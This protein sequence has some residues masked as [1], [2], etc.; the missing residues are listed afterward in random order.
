MY[1]NNESYRYKDQWDGAK[2]EKKTFRGCY[3]W[4]QIH[5]F[6][7]GIFRENFGVGAYVVLMELLLDQESFFWCWIEQ[8]LWFD[9]YILY[10]MPFVV[11]EIYTLT[12]VG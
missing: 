8:K 9:A 6:P 10:T 1:V 11:V 7:G 12:L 2:L 4:Y 5:F 3:D